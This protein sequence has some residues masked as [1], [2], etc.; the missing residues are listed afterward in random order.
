MPGGGPEIIQHLANRIGNRD[1]VV[2]EIGPVERMVAAGLAMAAGECAILDLAW[3]YTEL[4][5]DRTDRVPAARP[6]ADRGKAEGP[7]CG[8]SLRY[9]A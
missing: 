5:K 7:W 4:G 2:L 9:A 3:R 1:T 8:L 6:R